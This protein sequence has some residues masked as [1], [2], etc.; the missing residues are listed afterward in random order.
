MAKAKRIFCVVA[1]DIEDDR[2]R[3]KV[4]GLLE[5][6]GVRVNYSVFECMFTDKQLNLTRKAIEELIDTRADTVVYYPV[7]V[8]CFTKIV[9]Q[10]ERRQIIKTVRI[11]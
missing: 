8:D 5:K 9:Y 11:V 2:A 6:Y 7:C 10:P 1:Y 3:N 4:S